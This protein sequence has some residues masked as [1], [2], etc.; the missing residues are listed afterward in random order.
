MAQLAERF[1][2][3]L[4]AFVL[5]ANRNDCYGLAITKSSQRDCACNVGPF[6]RR[7]MS[8][9]LVVSQMGM[10]PRFRVF[11]GFPCRAKD[12]HFTSHELYLAARFQSQRTSSASGIEGQVFRAHCEDGS[13]FPP[14]LSI[15]VD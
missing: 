10:G 2:L 4:H 1:G 3:E 15:S 6:G 14:A 13:V 12:N 7:W 5:M 11:R 9:T 8:T